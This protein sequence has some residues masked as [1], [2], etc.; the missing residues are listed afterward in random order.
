MI[1]T[2]PNIGKLVINKAELYIQ[3]DTLINDISDIY[4]LS[5][6]T[7]NIL[8]FSNNE[9]EIFDC[10]VDILISKIKD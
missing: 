8:I 10:N 4:F 2:H 3:N 7:T 9:E 5:Y 1:L 6:F